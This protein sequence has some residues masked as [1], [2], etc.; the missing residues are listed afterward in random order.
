M[1]LVPCTDLHPKT[2]ELT[3]IHASTHLRWWLDPTVD[4]AY[5]EMVTRLWHGLQ[6][7]ED[8][9]II[10]QDIGINYSVIPEFER[11]RK[12]W[13]AHAYPVQGRPVVALGC[14]RFT[15]ELRTKEP[16]LMDVALKTDVDGFGPGHWRRFD[17]AVE[18]EL[19]KR[20][21]AVHRHFPDVEHFH[22][23]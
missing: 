21:Y 17:V 4:H 10:E 1:I 5:A 11:C 18:R 15:G 6:G 23:Y 8:L 12:P 16:D 22:E 7:L 14:V 20:G 9:T 3:A 19:K 2:A 13:C